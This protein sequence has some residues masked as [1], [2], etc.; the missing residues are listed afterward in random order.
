ML[1]RLLI[2]ALALVLALEIGCLTWFQ[3]PAFDGLRA[4][5][6]EEVLRGR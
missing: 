5:M 2:A 6:A 3:S 4:I 1:M